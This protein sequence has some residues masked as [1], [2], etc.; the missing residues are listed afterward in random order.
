MAEQK[1]PATPARK[2]TTKRGPTKATALKALGLTQEDLNLIKDLQKTQAEAP[3][4]NIQTLESDNPEVVTAIAEAAIAEEDDVKREDTSGIFYIRNLRNIEVHFRL[5]RQ[6]DKTKKRTNLNPRGQR[7]D[8]VK[9]EP[10]DLED[11]E[12][13]TQINYGLVEII[14]AAEA[15]K[16]LAGQTI[17]QQQRVHPAMASLRN[18]LDKPYE[19]GAVTVEASYED[20]GV[21]VANLKPQGGGAGELASHGRSIDWEAARSTNQVSTPTS[22][23]LISDGFAA[24]GVAAD[25]IARRNDLEGPAA[26]LGGITNVVVEPVQHT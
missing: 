6:S 24:P 1:K 15:K 18:E 23:G 26:G 21:V 9:L 13:N 5:E 20:Q 4:L 16:V 10:E 11:H 12:L 2:R 25:A 17:N 3:S 22:N 7:G 14:T 19:Q 8:L